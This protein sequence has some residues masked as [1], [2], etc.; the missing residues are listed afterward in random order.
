ML[1]T[2]Q[3]KDSKRN[4]A[5]NAAHGQLRTELETVESHRSKK[6]GRSKPKSKAKAKAAAAAA[7]AAAAVPRLDLQGVG[8]RVVV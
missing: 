2:I 3:I 7:A 5:I 8:Q 1:K 4:Q 6:G